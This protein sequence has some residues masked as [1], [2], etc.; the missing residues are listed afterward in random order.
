MTDVS[1]KSNPL[2]PFD[3]HGLHG[4]GLFSS[5]DTF[6]V[7]LG[8]VLE[9]LLAVSGEMFGVEYRQLNVVLAEEVQQRLLALV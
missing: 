8:G 4:C 1:I 5:G 9:H 7:Q 6:P 3:L 2:A